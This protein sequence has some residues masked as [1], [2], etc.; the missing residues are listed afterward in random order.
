[1]SGLLLGADGTVIR[2]RRDEPGLGRGTNRSSRHREAAPGRCGYRKAVGGYV[3][4]R[5]DSANRG[6]KCKLALRRYQTDLGLV[7]WRVENSEVLRFVVFYLP[8]VRLFST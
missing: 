1:M 6:P 2:G 3:D 4:R 7:L 5:G 8:T